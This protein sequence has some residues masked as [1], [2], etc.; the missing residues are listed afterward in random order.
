MRMLEIDTT[1]EIPPSPS[2]N[3]T[4]ASWTPGLKPI[5]FDEEPNLYR[6][7][8]LSYKASLEQ[9]RISKARISMT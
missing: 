8:H 2:P 9:V 7:Y 1:R 5:F 6:S 4:R 3:P